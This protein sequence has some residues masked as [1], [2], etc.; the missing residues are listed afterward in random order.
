MKIM[1]LCNGGQSSRIINH[2][3]RKW[4]T[5]V[6]T[7][8]ITPDSKSKIK[9]RLKRYGIIQG[10]GQ[11]LFI[12]YTRLLKKASINRITEIYQQFDLKEEPIAAEYFCERLTDPTLLR[13]IKQE[14]PDI[15]IISGVGIIPTS[16]LQNIRRPIINI[17]AGITPIFRGV[18][19]AYWALREKK[20]EFIG[21][22]IH[23]VDRG[24]DTGQ[25]LKR[26]TFSTT[27]RDNIATYPILHLAYGIQALK[28]VLNEFIESGELTVATDLDVTSKLRV[29][30]TIWDYFYHRVKD[31][32]K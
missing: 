27:D 11:L 9:N 29:H 12:L 2:A 28:A 32:V 31:G 10:V 4:D 30:P 17:H 15:I 7:I 16:V 25:V 8:I 3:I 23:L 24:I 5:D 1:L 18:H 22:T 20:R 6:V 13:H 14:N 19:G 21:S 26:I